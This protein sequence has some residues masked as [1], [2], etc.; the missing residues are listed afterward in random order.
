MQ[1]WGD[2]YNHHKA[3][4]MDQSDAA[5]RAD[6]WEKRQTM[7]VEEELMATNDALVR[8]LCEARAQIAAIEATDRRLIEENGKLQAQIAAKGNVPPVLDELIASLEDQLTKTED[9]LREARA[10]IAAKDAEI[11]HLKQYV[12]TKHWPALAAPARETKREAWSDAKE[13]QAA[14]DLRRMGREPK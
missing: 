13:E 3:K 11:K 4:G 7:N 6:E 10:Q 2:V 1:T 8:K 5:F 14:R 9:K 12:P